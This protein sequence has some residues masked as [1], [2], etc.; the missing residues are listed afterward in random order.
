M[1]NAPHPLGM[2]ASRTIQFTCTGRVETFELE[3]SQQ[4]SESA[5]GMPSWPL[6]R[7]AWGPGPERQKPSGVV[8]AVNLGSL[9]NSSLPTNPCLT[10][11][12]VIGANLSQPFSTRLH[13]DPDDRPCPARPRRKRPRRVISPTRLSRWRVVT[14][15]SDTR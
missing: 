6:S 10:E 15:C 14:P 12:W 3:L 2:P 9:G 1:C 8:S 13:H 5:A 11:D 7:M 4:A